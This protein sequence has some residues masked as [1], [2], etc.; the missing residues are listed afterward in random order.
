MNSSLNG[1]HALLT[2]SQRAP[3]CRLVV[4]TTGDAPLAEILRDAWDAFDL[5]CAL[6]KSTD[7]ST[8]L[9]R[10][11]HVAM[12]GRAPVDPVLQP[13]LPTNRSPWRSL[14][15]YELLVG[16]AGHAKLWR[17]LIEIEGEP[18]Y[19]DLAAHTGLSL[20][21]VSNY[22]SEVLRSLALHGLESP[23]MREMQA[24]AKRCRALLEPHIE[25]RLGQADR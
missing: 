20:S 8:V 14:E 12:H 2:L 9:R 15:G 24:F 10:L 25:R 17:A 7:L 22:R 11:R 13:L 21:A 4:Y 5:A 18:S 3:R 6:S 23:R 19:K 16:H 1:L